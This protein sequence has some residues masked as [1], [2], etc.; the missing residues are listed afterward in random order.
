MATTAACIC[1]TAKLLTE[2]VVFGPEKVSRSFRVSELKALFMAET[3][4]ELINTETMTLLQD[5]DTLEGLP[6]AVSL[7]VKKMPQQNIETLC[8][9]S[10]STPI[11]RRASWEIRLQE[12]VAEGDL[13][14]SQ[15]DQEYRILERIGLGAQASVYR[16]CIDPHNEHFAVKVY[17][18][19][20]L[21]SC[22]GAWQNLEREIAIL[23]C[24]NHPRIINL[25]DRCESD[26]HHYIVTDLAQMGNMLGVCQESP[27]NEQEAHFV[28]W[29]MLDALSYMHSKNIIHR[30]IKLENILVDKV[31]QSSEDKLYAIKVADFGFSK[32]V[33]L[34]AG[35][36]MPSHPRLERAVSKVGTPTYMAP[37]IINLQADAEY[38]QSVDYW[39]LGVC[40]YEMLMQ[41]HPFESEHTYFSQT[42]EAK[43]KRRRTESENFIPNQQKLQQHSKDVQDLITNLL[44]VEATARFGIDECLSHPWVR[45]GGPLISFPMPSMPSWVYEAKNCRC[46][47]PLCDECNERHR[48]PCI[49][50]L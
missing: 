49:F 9:V 48:Q 11:C 16:C 29:Q 37:E 46:V 22:K 6:D 24:I 50:W 12:N 30:D 21:A 5:Q 34:Q 10:D 28:F 43:G 26:Q 41:M 25:V 7:Y 15:T 32:Q 14:T 18:K 42:D 40:L 27:L 31:V 17:P 47:T 20:K 4:K 45:N 1:V 35:S 39:S 8:D 19:S 44:E 36:N 3:P 23:T 2:E 13:F 38:N 33:A